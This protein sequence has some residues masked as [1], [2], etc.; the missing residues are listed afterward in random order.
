MIARTVGVIDTETTGLTL[1][2]AAPLDQQPR[3]V[4]V[5]LAQVSR[6]NGKLLSRNE[7]LINPGIPIPPEATK[8]H[9]LTDADVADAPTFAQ[10]WPL[11]AKQFAKCDKLI[12][13]N[14]PF[15]E[16]MLRLELQRANIKWAMPFECTIGLFREQFGYDMKLVQL[17]EH[18]MGKKLSQIHRAGSDV[19]ALVE[20]VQALELWKN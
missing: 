5:A 1:H 6:S 14:A 12:A 11:L 4:E 7:W 20:I 3:L 16:S 18:V 13:H 19:D 17:Y 2:P 10:A 9:K 15:D 8:V